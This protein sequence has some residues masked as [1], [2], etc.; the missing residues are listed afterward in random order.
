MAC[1]LL[2]DE[3]AV[4]GRAMQGILARGNHSCVIA[5]S[6]ADAWRLL[7]EGVVVDL[8]FM[9]TKL[10]G[11][12]QEGMAFLQRVRDDWFWK[13]LP[14]V[15][16]TTLADPQLVR[17]AVGLQV[18]N[19]LVKPYVDQVV[20]DELAKALA[21]PWRNLL[22][23]ESRSFC[24]L[25]GLK[26][27]DLSKMRRAVMDAF[28]DAAR[29][30]PVW[31]ETRRNTEVFERIDALVN[32][33]EAAGIWAGVDYLKDLRAQAE[34]QNWP[35]FKSAAEYFEYASR[36]IFCQLN[37]Q[38]VPECLRSEMELNDARDA[39][40][41]ARWKHV[42]VDLS[43]P[44]VSA[45][46]I[47]KQVLGLTGCPVIDAA[48]AAFHMAADGRATSMTHVMEIVSADPGL[49][50]QVLAA[51]NKAEHDEMTAIDDPRTAANLLGEIKLQ[52][53]AKNM[54]VA[55]E[56]YFQEKPFTWANYWTF[57]V[58]VGRVSQ[59][60]CEYLEFSYL[61]SNAFTAGLMHDLGKLI[62]W[63]LHPFGLEAML[64]YVGEKKVTLRAAERKHIGCTSRELGVRFAEA[65][66]L[67]KVYTNVIRWVEE[68]DLAVENTDLVAMVSLARHVC[69]HNRVG[70]CG[71]NA[72][73][74]PI[75]KTPAWQALQPRLFPSFDLKRFE[76]QAH[77]YCVELRQDLAGGSNRKRILV[78]EPATTGR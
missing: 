7:R 34:T 11:G 10:G 25:L 24:A 70:Y 56:R 57:L 30:F 78:Q 61:T 60:I 63:K 41:R 4:A 27:D 43:G 47:E 20:L 26:P 46:E 1:I 65:S 13:N 77:A 35:A 71:E 40:E 32:D 2:L 17:R 15:V 44:V 29:I 55:Y 33:A 68:P 59:F 66:G 49:C 36:L 73:D 62:L 54:P 58:S 12:G 45:E 69:L 52:T 9:E 31:A 14:V 39:T 23:E 5:S 16:Y 76:A 37:P 72:G 8:V 53:L 21:N 19:Y 6:F 28:D 22:F 48:A 67:P 75:A 3:S 64:R 50:A 38:H 51:A 74:L 42:D 18:Q